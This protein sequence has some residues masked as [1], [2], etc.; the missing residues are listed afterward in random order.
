MAAHLLFVLGP[1]VIFCVVVWGLLQV[2][3]TNKQ[4][5]YWEKLEWDL[6][7]VSIPQDAINTPKGM[8]NF[9]NNL[10]GSK[11]AIT[12]YEEWI[13]GKF[14]AY[15]SF[16]IVSI[17][18]NIQYYIRTI[19]KYRDLAE[20]ALYG[21]YP[22]A[23]IV[24]VED[25]AKQF[26]LEFPNEEWNC[27]GSEMS[28]GKDSYFPLKTYEMF[29][30]Q[31]EK[32]LRFKDPILPM[33]E[34]LGK[35]V[36]GEIFAIQFLILSPESQDWRK[37]GLKFIAK[38]YGKEEKKKQGMFD[39][40]IGWIPKEIAT[41]VAGFAFGGSE[42]KPKADDFR[43]FKITPDERDLLD[44]VKTKCTQI[45]WHGKARVIYLAQHELYRKGTIAAM[46]KGIFN[47]FDSGWNKLGLTD[48]CTPKD[49]Y[50]WQ[51]WVMPEKQR[52]LVKKYRNRSF[53]AGTTP[54]IL[55]ASELA[56]MFHFPPADAKTPALTSINSRMSEAPRE[57]SYAPEGVS[58]LANFERSAH[59]VYKTAPQAAQQYAPPVKISLPT[60]TAPTSG[61][62]YQTIGAQPYSHQEIVGPGETLPKVGMPAPLP[63][64][65]DIS[66]EPLD[67]SESPFNLP[68]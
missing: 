48:S 53:G 65:L 44:A 6:L 1:F 11:S 16:E 35:M 17:G 19:K 39:D 26:P 14:Q 2:W 50:F 32:D 9:F 29:E 30:H 37:A 59:D 49:D 23:Q 13:L 25:Y 57:L 52:K 58:V 10:A 18:G 4:D 43:M 21:Q 24:E 3:L 66:D 45:G 68:I 54:Y 36:P 60:P 12:K 55:T 61:V 33:L 8:E 27:F 31:G 28:M 41:Q 34:M 38:M 67:G 62:A 7:A 22:E 56:T 51:E 46:I 40:V 47:Q 15:F 20:A 63:P 42:E 5:Q 64:G